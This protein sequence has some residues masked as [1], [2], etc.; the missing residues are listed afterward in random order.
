MVIVPQSMNDNPKT[1]MRYILSYAVKPETARHIT[2]G[3]TTRKE[4]Q[5]RIL[6]ISISISYVIVIRR[7]NIAYF[8]ANFHKK[9]PCGTV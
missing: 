7:T 1:S 6:F 3:N 8:I 5:K 4:L 2:L 9:R